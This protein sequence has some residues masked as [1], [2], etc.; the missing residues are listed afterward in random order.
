[1]E[2]EKLNT[3]E[4]ANSDLGAVSTRFVLALETT[5]N[6]IKGKKYPLIDI[7]DSELYYYIID[8]SGKETSYWH[9]VLNEC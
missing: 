8:E 1:M 9:S 2:H 4:T 5:D 7:D 6:I 3:E